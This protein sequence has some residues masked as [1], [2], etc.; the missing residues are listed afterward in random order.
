V[1]DQGGFTKAASTLNLS[2]PAISKSLKELED[3]L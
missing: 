2:Q 3:G 1:V